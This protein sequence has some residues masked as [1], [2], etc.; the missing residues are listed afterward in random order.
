VFA[1]VLTTGCEH[2]TSWR[3]IWALYYFAKEAQLSGGNHVY[4]AWNVIEHLANL[5][6]VDVVFLNLHDGDV[7]YPLDATMKENFKS[8]E[9]VLSKQPVLTSPKKKVH[10]DC[11]K[12]RYLLYVSRKGLRQTFFKASMLWFEA[13]SRASMS[14]SSWRLYEMCD[15]KYLNV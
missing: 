10:W 12:R 13:A 4:D 6:I 8:L 9:K 15:P 3:V 2:P 1:F 11:T 14:A 5:F 7:E